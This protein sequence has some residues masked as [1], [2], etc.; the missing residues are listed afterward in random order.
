MRGA[1]NGRG[2]RCRV[3]S[4]LMSGVRTAIGTGAL[5]TAI[6]AGAVLGGADIA[7]ATTDTTFG[8]SARHGRGHRRRHRR[9]ARG[10]AR[11]RR[12]A[13]RLGAALQRHAADGRGRRRGRGGRRHRHRHRP[14]RHGD[15]LSGRSVNDTARHTIPRRLDDPER[16]L[17][18]TVDEAAAL[19]G[20]ALLGPRR[21]PVRAGAD[22][23]RRRLAACCAGSSAAA[24]P[25]SR[26]TPSTGSC[27]TSCCA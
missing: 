23:R 18:W 24:A 8:D 6:V 7:F 2:R 11:R 27:P 9:A 16:W 1:E 17:F 26:A 3:A 4:P 10:R 5:A 14:G 12:G 15:R 25:T 20:P 13:G 21:Q 22:C 19:M